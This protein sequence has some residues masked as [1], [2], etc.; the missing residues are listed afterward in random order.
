MAAEGGKAVAGVPIAFPSKVMP[1]GKR[2]GWRRRFLGA[3]AVSQTLEVLVSRT[4]AASRAD[5][6]QEILH[7]AAAHVAVEEE[8]ETTEHSSFSDPLLPSEH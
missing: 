6:S 3:L 8:G 4:L 1:S 2:S 7:D 5:S